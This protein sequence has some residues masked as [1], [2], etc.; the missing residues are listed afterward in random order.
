MIEKPRFHSRPEAA[1]Q[2]KIITFLENKEWLIE[3]MHGN[4]FQKGIP[5]LFCWHINFGF[6]WIDVKL[7]TGSDLTKAQCQ[8]W[9]SWREKGL[10]IHIMKAATE[11]EYKKIFGPAN[12]RELWRPRHEKYIREVS[13]ILEELDE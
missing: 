7:P 5:D 11:D 6:R 4:A 10:K 3:V 8:K 13:N 9:T 1:L 2:K 12:W